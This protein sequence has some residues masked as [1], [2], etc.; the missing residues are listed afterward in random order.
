MLSN[1][2]CSFCFPCDLACSTILVLYLS[3]SLLLNYQSVYS[4]GCVWC[5]LVIIYQ[6]EVLTGNVPV[7][8]M[9]VIIYQLKVLIGNVP[10]CCMLVIIYQLEV[11]TGNVPVCC[12]LVI[13]YQLE[14]FT[15][16]VPGADCEANIYVTLFGSRG[17][18]GRRQLYHSLSS[19]TKFQQGQK[20]VFNIEAVDLGNLDKLVIRHDGRGKGQG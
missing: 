8:C 1:S 12:M 19:R 2:Y 7:C 10:V 15:G 4:S 11:L 5:M 6:L 9:L 14:V 18:A 13:I 17:D 20:D 16:N 3:C